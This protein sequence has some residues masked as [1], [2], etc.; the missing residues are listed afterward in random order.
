MEEQE[1]RHA[2]KQWGWQMKGSG[3]A[4]KGL[5]TWTWKA[6]EF[7]WDQAGV[8]FIC[9]LRTLSGLI[10][11]ESSTVKHRHDMLRPT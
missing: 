5:G 7:G 10:A 8:L 4:G 9:S 6:G 3:R 2:G 1:Q 11:T